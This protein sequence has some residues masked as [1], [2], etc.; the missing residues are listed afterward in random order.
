MISFR[1]R[2]FCTFYEGC[3]KAAA[4]ECDRPLTP[5]VKAQ[6]REWWGGEDAPIS[7][8]AE[9]PDCFEVIVKES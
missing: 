9:I 4:L 8:Y 5:E 6:A 1:D 3:A 7:V 2:T